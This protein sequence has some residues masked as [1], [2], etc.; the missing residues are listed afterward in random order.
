MEGLMGEKWREDYAT[1]LNISQSK[2]KSKKR[3]EELIKRE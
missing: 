1:V 3:E 2:K